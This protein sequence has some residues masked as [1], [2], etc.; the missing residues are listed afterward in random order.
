MKITQVYE[1]VNNMTKEVLGETEVLQED[2]SKE[3]TFFG[4]QGKK[5]VFN[6][7]N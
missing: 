5:Y 6:Y 4:I 1:L 7:R 2:L 3:L